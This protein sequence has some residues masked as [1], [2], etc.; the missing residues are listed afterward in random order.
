VEVSSDDNSA[1]QLDEMIDHIDN[2]HYHQAQ[3]EFNKFEVFKMR[4]FL[5]ELE[6]T[7]SLKNVTDEGVV[8]EIGEGTVKKRGKDLPK[9]SGRNLAD[10]M[11]SNGRFDLLPFFGD[12][13]GIFPNINILIQREASRRVV[14][15]GCERIFSIA[16]YVSS[17]HRSNLNVR[18]YER[19]SLLAVILSRVYVSPKWVADEYLRRCKAGAWKKENT[20]ESS[21]CFNIE[22]II[23]AEEKGLE[24]PDSLTVDEYVAQ[25]VAEGALV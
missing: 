20:V 4:A 8:I 1:H 21:K 14:E 5:P 13:K 18:N 16:D 15:V 23:K 9:P 11:Q 10:Y 2:E 24:A 3:K 22:R 7:K 19:L 12:H 25:A 6:F 17:P